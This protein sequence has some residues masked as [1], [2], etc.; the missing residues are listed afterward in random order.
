MKKSNIAVLVVGLVLIPLALYLGSRLPG[1]SYYLIGTLIIIAL[2][3]PF[4][5]AFEGRRPQARELVT[6]AVLCALA[7]AC[8][9]IIPI[10][11]FKPIFAI[12]M[13]SGIAFGPETGFLVGA[14]SAFISDF[15]YGQ[16]PYTPWQMMGYG[17]AGL[18]AGLVFQSRRIP[19]RG[20]VLAFFGF[21]TVVLAAGPLLDSASVFLMLPEI[22]L[23]N[24]IPVFLAGLPINL[25]QGACTFV[26]MLL[27]GRPLLDKLERLKVKYGMMEGENGI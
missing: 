18:L 5:L 4:F 1:R 10:P 22:T 13:L 21:F 24:A 8:R 12:I 11:H 25:S 15:M 19:R 16:G 14:V 3:I 2:L 20:L 6:I 9:A 7:V 17:A 23:E 26:T 27:F